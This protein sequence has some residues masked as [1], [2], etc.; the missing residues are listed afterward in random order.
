VIGVARQDRASELR[1]SLRRWAQDAVIKPSPITRAEVVAGVKAAVVPYLVSRFL[2]VV[3]TV[4]G[5]RNFQAPP[6]L[7]SNLNPPPALAPF[8]HW[9]ADAYGYIAHHGYGLGAGGVTAEAIRVAWFPFYPLLIHLTGGSDWAMFLIPN[10]CFFAALALLYVVA[11]R[12]MDAD[13]A[14]L[15]LWLI[16]L[17][18]A[19]M[20]FSYPYTESVFLLLT[21]GAFV[22]MESG[23]WLLAG[24]AGL[25]AAATRFPGVLV[26]AALGGEAALGNR[27]RA[28]L[29]AIVL[30]VLGL[31]VVSLVDWAQMG[32]PL[33]FVH[34]R[35]F[36]IGPDRNPLYLVGSFPKAVIEGDPFNPEAIG[37]PVLLL[38]AVGAAWVTRRMPIAYGAFAV[39]QVIV[40]ADQ[41]LYLHI[42]SL[43]PRV[44]SVIFPC[45]F[46]FA[47][48]L[49]PRR[50]LQLG[51]LLISA[52]AMVVLAVMYGG[53]RFIG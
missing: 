17:G 18:P 9:D 48:W 38:F 23:H 29:A 32:D 34:S 43:V 40:A 24:L 2:V 33:G 7:Y 20:F 27:R 41:G 45:Y 6:G 31:V 22:L 21:V 47:T 50:N 51:W 42:F 10:V 30:P 13:R 12:H 49:A 11:G 53:W 14:R 1:E 25:A 3:A 37:V 39:T 35:S 5:A 4:F 8:F 46:A 19:A 16:S 44:V 26:A 36:W 28:V 52:S 15:T